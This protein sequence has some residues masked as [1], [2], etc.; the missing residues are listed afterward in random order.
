MKD[1]LL[2][3]SGGLAQEIAHWSSGY[4]NFIGYTGKILEKGTVCSFP[5]THFS[6]D[7]INP[8]IAKTTN[9]FIAVASPKIRK[10]LYHLYK[11]KGFQFP[12]FIDA[13]SRITSSVKLKEG[14]FIGPNCVVSSNV[15]IGICSII[16]FQC[17]IGHDAKICDF[18]QVNPGAQVG[19]NVTVGDGTLIGSNATILQGI[20]LE[21]D[22]IVASGAT[23]FKKVEKGTTVMGNPARKLKSFP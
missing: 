22:V 3:G 12:S 5:K 14:V 11:L 21:N 19:G 7:L 10:R 8:T 20:N 4:F 16:N 9:V 13:S 6:E 17:G 23:V 2:V 18:V 1:L 15:C